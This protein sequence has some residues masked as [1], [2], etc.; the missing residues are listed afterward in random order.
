MTNNDIEAAA[1]AYRAAREATDDN[2]RVLCFM[3]FDRI[4]AKL[5]PKEIFLLEKKIKSVQK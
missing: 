1:N 5:S 3:E 2:Q 4:R